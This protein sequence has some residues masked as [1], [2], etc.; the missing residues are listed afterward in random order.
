MLFIFISKGVSNI[1]KAKL[2]EMVMERIC[3]K[4]K[5]VRVVRHLDELVALKEIGYLREVRPA[6]NKPVIIQINR[7]KAKDIVEYADKLKHT[8]MEH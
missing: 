3:N 4:E 8:Q 6:G 7:A 2:V 5:V 1:F